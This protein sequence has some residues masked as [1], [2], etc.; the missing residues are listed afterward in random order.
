[1]EQYP[2]F[3]TWHGGE[4]CKGDI[5]TMQNMT[6][7]GE[8]EGDNKIIWL[9]VIIFLPFIGSIIYLLIGRGQQIKR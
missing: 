9:L 5:T 6:V 2:Q 1:M 4:L 8:F 3:L 7:T